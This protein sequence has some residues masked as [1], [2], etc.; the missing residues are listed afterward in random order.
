[1]NCNESSLHSDETQYMM[2]GP[3]NNNEPHLNLILNSF[4]IERVYAIKYL[5]VKFYPQ[6]TRKLH[7]DHSG[8]KM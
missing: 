2:Y 1:M 5:E 3:A 4:Q 6:L 7:I 8:Q